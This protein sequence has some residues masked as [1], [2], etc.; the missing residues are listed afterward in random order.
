[1]RLARLAA[2]GL[3]LGLVAGFAGAL[4]RPR[5]GTLS[6]KTAGTFGDRTSTAP[7]ADDQMWDQFRK[8][9][10]SPVVELRAHRRVTG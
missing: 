8:A 1:M 10:E 2:V 5:P 6:T 9:E 7:V 4:L 3:A